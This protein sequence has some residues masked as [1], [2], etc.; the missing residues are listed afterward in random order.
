MKQGLFILTFLL[1]FSN[2][3]ISQDRNCNCLENLNRL[4]EKTEENYAGF[5]TKVNQGTKAG[6]QELVK[7]VKSRASAVTRPEAC[8]Y[9]LKEYI[10]YFKDKHF[11]L[12][13]IGNKRPETEMVTLSEKA[14]RES[15]S[16]KTADPIEGIWINPE[17]T[18]K[19]AIRRK[20][21][22]EFQGIVLESN[23]PAVPV[24]LVYFTFIKT[25]KGWIAEEFNAYLSTDFVT[26]QKG[27][28][29]QIWNQRMFG[30][31]YPASMSAREQEEL[32]TWKGSNNGLE[33]KKLSDKTAY[34]KI[35]TFKNNDD[36]IMQL[37]AQNDSIIKS[38]ENFIVD[39]TG[40]AGGNTGW[41]AFLPYFMT[42]PIIQ[43]DSYLRVT[44]E[45]VKHKLAD[46]EPFAVNPI[47]DEY[48]K[49]FPDEILA[50]YKKAYQ[51]LPTTK[52]AF[53]PVP[54]VIFPLDSVVAKPKK[55]ALIVDEFCGSSA[56]YFFFISRQSRK[57]TTYGTH[58]VGMMDYEG[59]SN[60]TPLPYDGFILTI[61]IVK[62]S[63]TDQKPID[64]TGFKPDIL[65]NK[66]DRR[67]WIEFVKKDLERK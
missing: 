1:S 21:A 52:K 63:W 15:L 67:Q 47:P 18:L 22:N 39:L 34:L 26:R 49:Y 46:L 19:M 13:Y 42:N 56:E 58:T 57:T 54:G 44:P 29:L 31:I 7:S 2:A 9:L 30:K 27:N 28:L 64:Q 37:V 16:R 62:S 40:N 11:I 12:S 55:I 61:P 23:D 43:Y 4:I 33:F 8:Y 6:Y 65:L 45:N 66:I 51:E 38:C 59:M 35:P 17:N 10:R 20:S 3:L 41:V 50:K 36:K 60:P 32:M 14:F 25:A 53:Y 48:K 24:G 5:P